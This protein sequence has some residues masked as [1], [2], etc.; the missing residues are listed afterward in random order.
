LLAIVNA[1]NAGSIRIVEKLGLVFQR[2]VSL[3]L[4]APEVNLF[5]L[6][7]TGAS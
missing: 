1:D 2:S 5:A 6:E 4:G 3:S 7:A